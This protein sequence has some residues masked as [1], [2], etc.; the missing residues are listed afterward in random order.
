M[1]KGVNS[2]EGRT[3]TYQTLDEI[4]AHFPYYSKRQIERIINHLVHKGVLIK[5]NFNDTGYDRT[6]WYAFINEDM[7]TIS[8]NG[9]MDNTK[10]GNQKHQTVKS[11]IL[12][13]DTRKDIDDAR[14]APMKIKKEILPAVD[15]H[16]VF[17]HLQGLVGRKDAEILWM[18]ASRADYDIEPVVNHCMRSDTVR[19]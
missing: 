4:Q 9:E 17:C 15:S 3:W 7:F 12:D 6:L 8:P 2:R 18:N 1:R 11:T 10:R 16:P 13:K 5:G 19:S 14:E